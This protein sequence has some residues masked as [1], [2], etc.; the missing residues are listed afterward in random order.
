MKQL[1]VD[2]EP[3]NVNGVIH[4]GAGTGDY[5]KNYHD[6]GIHQVLWIEADTSLYT[7]LYEGIKSYGMEQKILITE[8]D[9]VSK[10]PGVKSFKTLW[11]ENAS[12]INPYTYDMLHIACKTKHDE[13]LGGFS[14]LLENFK[15]IVLS[16]D[17]ENEKV[18]R[19][20][21]SKGFFLDSFT[22][23]ERLFIKR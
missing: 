8:L 21:N 5:A 14:F 15:E 19:T 23:N 18:E 7:A 10:P 16:Q 17:C 20:L 3:L 12:Y 22:D 9:L 13:I 11:R 4:V 1:Q 2:L 6:L